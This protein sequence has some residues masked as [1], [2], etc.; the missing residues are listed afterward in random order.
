[1]ARCSY[2]HRGTTQMA[3]P[4][5]HFSKITRLAD[6]TR[7]GTLC[8]RMTGGEINCTEVI[9]EVTCKLCLR[10]IDFRLSHSQLT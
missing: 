5:T 1:M 4:V 7:V 3:K 2:E 9:G 6:C 8:N 10:E